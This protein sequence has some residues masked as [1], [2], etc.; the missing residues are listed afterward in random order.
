[1]VLQDILAESL[2]GV[3]LF[4]STARGEDHL[5]SDVDLLIVVA[6]ALPLTRRLYAL[7]DKH[8]SGELYSPHFVH[9]PED[10]ASAGSIW[11]E[12]AVDGV[13]LY[14]VDRQISRFLSRIRRAIADGEVLRKIA[15]GH[16]YWI[17]REEDWSDVQ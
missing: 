1:M 6:S 3:V 17:R 16:P 13:I 10:I 8:L 12:T 5:A 2:L 15:D 9:L 14:E 7:W 11:F 4:G